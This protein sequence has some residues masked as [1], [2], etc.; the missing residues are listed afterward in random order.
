MR[1]MRDGVQV[2]PPTQRKKRHQD[3]ALHRGTE[4]CD[5]I[6]FLEIDLRVTK[7]TYDLARLLGC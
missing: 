4:S 6:Y 1:E 5:S 3:I 7:A 2:S